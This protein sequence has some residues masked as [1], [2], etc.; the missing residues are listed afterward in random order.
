M[1][2]R[3]TQR[4]K[5]FVTLRPN[6]LRK[7][8]LSAKRYLIFSFS[9]GIDMLTINIVGRIVIIS[10][11][12]ILLAHEI[13][14]KNTF[15]PGGHVEYNEGAK[16]AILRELKEEF[17]GEGKIDKFIGVIEHSFEH[18]NQPYYEL[19]LLFSGS[20]LNYDYPQIPESLESHLKFY[21]QPI[22]KLKEVN[23]LPS[24]LATVIHNYFK[25]EKRNSLWI[26][27]MENENIR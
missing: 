11:T 20:L 14:A 22:E 15:L 8:L 2:L 17:N 27:T 21:W 16:S 18:N 6:L 25:Q 9:R 4:I 1:Q 13:G 19:N 3:T 26:S 10:E 24:P 12:Y 7:L 23:L 5:G